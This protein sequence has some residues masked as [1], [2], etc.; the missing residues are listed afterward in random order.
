MAVTQPIRA[1]STAEGLVALWALLDAWQDHMAARG[2]SAETRDQY[3]SYLLRGLRR[4]RLTP[5]TATARSL[6]GFIAAVPPKGTNRAAYVGAFKSFFRFV[7]REHLRDDNPALDLRIKPPKYPPPDFFTPTEI[8]QILEAAGRRSTR[9]GNRRLALLLLFETGARI[10]SLASVE[11]RDLHG[12]PPSHVTFRITK[13][14]RPYRLALTPAASEAAVELLAMM[15]PGQRTLLGCHKVTLGNWFRDAARDAGMPEGRV[16]AHLARHTA[17]TMLYA[18]TK[19]PI[20]VK[21]YLNHADLSQVVRYARVTED[22][23]AEALAR[24]LTG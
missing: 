1:L 11:P 14:D 3:E 7:L 23:M 13:G 22:T 10:G 21:D 24:S 19:D 15:H 20:L 5:E 9:S 17:A 4:A 2:L 12:S 16:H 18:R 6:E 8:A